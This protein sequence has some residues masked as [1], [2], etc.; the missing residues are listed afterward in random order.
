MWNS[1]V[2][3]CVA[4]SAVKAEYIASSAAT[5]EVLFHQ[6]LL[7]GLGFNN[8]TPTIFTDNTGCI[9]VANDPVM[10]SKLKH[11]DTKYHL[12]CN[13]MQE[14][15]ISIKYIWTDDNITDFLTKPVIQDLL[16]HMHD[17]LGIV[18]V[19]LLNCSAGKGDS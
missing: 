17:W 3:K 12:I 5:R 10:H 2:Q 8:D 6:H 7:C 16:A 9:Q 14:G 18:N 13:H 15:D 1:H 4:S 11:V 19:G